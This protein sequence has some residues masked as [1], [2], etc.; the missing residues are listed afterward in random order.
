MTN[1][2]FSDSIMTALEFAM[3]LRNGTINYH[4]DY[5]AV[6]RAP[7]EVRF[8]TD[9]FETNYVHGA[10]MA[11]EEYTLCGIH[12]TDIENYDEGLCLDSKI[13]HITIFGNIA[14]EKEIPILYFDV[15]FDCLDGESAK[16][17][18]F[19]QIQNVCVH[20]LGHSYFLSSERVKIGNDEVTVWGQLRTP[21]A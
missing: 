12:A 10:N 21:D 11:L 15:V 2:K 20:Y 4:P 9:W 16:L 7:V 17:G 18:A 14:G 8:Q 13:R 5:S 19:W 6:P 1:I 3:K